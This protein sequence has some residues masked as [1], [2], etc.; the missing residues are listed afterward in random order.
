ML[1]LKT[2]AFSSFYLIAATG[3]LNFSSPAVAERT[4]GCGSG[5]SA[6]L[7]EILSP[8]GSNQ[9][10]VACDEHDDCYDTLGKSR[11]ECDNAFHNRMLGICARDHNTWFGKG[12]KAAC[13][14]RADAYYAGVKKR[15]EEAYDK[16]QTAAKKKLS[17][18]AQEAYQNKIAEGI[19]LR[20]QWSDKCLQTMGQDK[21]NGS[22]VNIWDCTNTSNQFWR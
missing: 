8:V 13:N 18:S 5:S 2:S 20:N 7:L 14:G 15:G 21:E 16:A 17:N 4:A 10:R 3:L 1:R 19:M 6:Y 9:F 11:Q 22:L 12:L